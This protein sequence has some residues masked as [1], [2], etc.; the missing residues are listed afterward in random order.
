MRQLILD[1]VF[2]NC[3]FLV[4]CGTIPANDR[5]WEVLYAP[6]PDTSKMENAQDLKDLPP[7]AEPKIYRYWR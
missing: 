4:G 1:M 3:L 7:A 5:E 6:L 2:V